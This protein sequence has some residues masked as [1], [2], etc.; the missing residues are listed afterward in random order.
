MFRVKN[1]RITD[2][3]VILTAR[4]GLRGKE[5]VKK[6]EKE[7]LSVNFIKP[8]ITGT[9]QRNKAKTNI[10]RDLKHLEILIDLKN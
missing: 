10:E 4:N 3:T 9:K 1:Y 8:D 5:A 2:R 6:L 7:K